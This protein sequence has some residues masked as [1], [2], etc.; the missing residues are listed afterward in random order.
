[1]DLSDD[2]KIKFIYEQIRTETDPER[3]AMLGEELRSLLT[4]EGEEKR[5]KS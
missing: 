3:I 5:S 1:M 2:E 4:K